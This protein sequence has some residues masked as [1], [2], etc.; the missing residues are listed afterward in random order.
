MRLQLYTPRPLSTSNVV[1]ITNLLCPDPKYYAALAKFTGWHNRFKLHGF[2][3]VSWS[4][5]FLVLLV[6]SSFP[7]A[8]AVADVDKKA[9]ELS[10]DLLHSTYLAHTMD[11]LTTPAWGTHLNT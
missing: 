11:F 5:C 9:Q 2:D 4:A 7:P 8:R 3:G 6:I 1:P 10:L